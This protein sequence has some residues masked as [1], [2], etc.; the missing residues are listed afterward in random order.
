[1]GINV[2]ASTSHNPMSLHG[3]LHKVHLL[4]GRECVIICAGN[5]TEEK[6]CVIMLSFP[7]ENE[8]RKYGDSIIYVT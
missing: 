7:P 8:Y 6:P 1:M 4:L 5:V 2:G 3:L